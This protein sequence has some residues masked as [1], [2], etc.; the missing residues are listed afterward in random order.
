MID[1]HVSPNGDDSNPG[2][3]AAPWRSLAHARDQVRKRRR[4]APGAVT[5]H[6]APGVHRLSETL[7]LGPDD[8]GDDG[9][10]VTWQGADGAVLSSGFALAGWQRCPVDL[11]DVPAPLRGRVW[12]VDLPGG[13]TVNTLY[14]ASGSVPRARGPAIKPQRCAVEAPGRHP[15]LLGPDG[16][17][18]DHSGF[19][20]G[21][22]SFF[23]DRF[24]FVPG[25]I[26]PAGDLREAEFL[27][28]PAMQW[29]MNILAPRDIDVANGVVLLANPCTYPIGNPPCAPE[30]SIWLENSLSVLEPGRWVYHATAARLYYCPKGDEPET[31]LEAA[32]LTEFIRVEGV[33]EI[34]GVQRHVQGIHFTNIRFTR[35]N[36]FAFHGLTGRGIQHDWEMHDAPS[37]ML[38]FRHAERCRVSDCRFS[39]GGSGGVRLDLACRWNRIERCEFAQLGGCA[40]VLCGYGLSRHYC[41]RDNAVV[42]N[43][44]HHIGRHYWHCPGIFIWQSGDN[45]IADNHIHDLPYTGIVCSGRTLYDRSG[46]AECSATID[47]SAVDEQCGAGYV[48]NVWHYGGLPSWSMREPLMHSRDNLIEYNRIH[49][50]MQV[51]GDGNGIYISGAGGGNVVRFNVVGPCPSPTMAEGIR[52]DDD[53][54]HAILHGNL[55][56]GM[57]GHATGIT[58]KGVNRV[59]NNILALPLRTPDRGLLSLEH[60]PLNGAVIKRNI[61][62]TSAPDQRLVAEMRY[63]G[64]G[65]KARLRDT[66]ADGNIYFCAGDPAAGLAWLAEQQSFGV[67]V[68]SRCVDPGFVDAEAGD[69]TLADAAAALTTGFQPLPLARMFAA[70]RSAG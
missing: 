15:Q 30:G 65:R 1:V 16:A 39:E 33:H 48:H 40:V 69:F 17:I 7:L 20:H 5:I 37:C 9:S 41:N 67:D 11:A 66:D 18:A 27:I 29:T 28:I 63:H 32:S 35:S 56:F 54:H 70:G 53:Q 42:G 44:V 22:S 2:T 55:V 31:G 58:I 62:Y 38:R 34:G 46:V 12:F 4:D 52:C 45:R 26:R 19:S 59:T 10:T 50:V 25:A 21:E 60:G 51:M 8:G 43:H 23:H 64:E 24:A 68:H 57:H 47:W 14:G 3:S 36:R 13:T 61:F 49:D 6:L